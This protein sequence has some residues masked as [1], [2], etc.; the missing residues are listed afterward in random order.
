MKKAIIAAAVATMATNAMALNIYNWNDY[1]SMT[2]VNDYKKTTPLKMDFYDSN[3][4][5]QG[6]IL[7]GNTKYDVIYPSLNFHTRFIQAGALE[8][9][10]FSK[11]PNAKNLDPA[12]M[13]KLGTAKSYGLPYT[14]GYSGIAI[15]DTKVKAILGKLPADEWDLLFNAAITTKLKNAGC[16]LTMMDSASEVLTALQIHLGQKP[17]DYSPSNV[18]AMRATLKG[19][20]SNITYFKSSPIDD[21]TSGNFCVAHAYNGDANIGKTNATAV[22]KKHITNVLAPSKGA[23][24]FFDMFAIP[25]GGNVAEASK[26]I[27]HNLDVNNARMNHEAISYAVSVPN[28][29]VNSPFRLDPSIVMTPDFLKKSPLLPVLDLQTQ[30]VQTRLWQDFKMGRL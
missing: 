19:M 22:K 15:N 23:P 27:N 25:K 18:A 4:M 24:I 9:L 3:E 10:D 30:K 2:V 26:W 11:I 1:N 21:I 13:A 6:K 14:V 12:I 17:G 7:V 16:S 5:L 8:K 29:M 20:R 28:A